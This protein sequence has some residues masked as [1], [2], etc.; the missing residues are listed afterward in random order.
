MRDLT[1]SGPIGGMIGKVFFYFERL[2]EIQGKHKSKD[3]F[4]RIDMILLEVL[5]IEDS[6]SPET[7]KEKQPVSWM[8]VLLL[9]ISGLFHWGLLGMSLFVLQV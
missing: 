6:K 8:G 5:S 7:L 2:K 4:K 1:I 9:C 3:I